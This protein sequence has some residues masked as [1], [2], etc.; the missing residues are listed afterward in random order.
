MVQT[1]K[2]LLE[3]WNSALCGLLMWGAVLLVAIPVRADL[4]EFYTLT[5]LG[6]LGGMSG[7]TISVA[8]GV[9]N[10]GHVV[11]WSYTPAPEASND[12]GNVTQQVFL[13]SNGTMGN[14]LGT[15]GG[16]ENQAYGINNAGQVVGTASRHAFVY[17]NN[18]ITDLVTL[19]ANQALDIND[20]GQV[21]GES[22]TTNA[23]Y[24]FLYSNG[25]MTD[26]GNL[27]GT[28]SQAQGTNDIGQVVGPSGTI[29]DNG[30]Q[31][32]RA[33][34]Y[35]NGSMTDL[36]TLGE[37][38]SIAFDINDAGQAV[39]YADVV[40]ITQPYHAFLYTNGT[41]TD[42]GTLGKTISEARGID[43]TGQVVRW[44]YNDG[45]GAYNAFVYRHGSLSNLN[46]LLD[47]SGKGW[48][49][50]E[51]IAVTDNGQMVGLG[52]NPLG[53]Q[54]A[55]LLTPIPGLLMLL[56][57]RARMVAKGFSF[58][59]WLVCGGG[60]GH[61]D[62]LRRRNGHSVPA[63]HGY[64]QMVSGSGNLSSSELYTKAITQAL[65]ILPRS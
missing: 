12:P 22:F 59:R 15:L 64:P 54:E 51:A 21:A 38:N 44:S 43:S 11:G 31:I 47:G 6:N 56:V 49:L 16:V 52:V 55:F 7:R 4:A 28:Y 48:T 10:A 45:D 37:P 42:V 60:G 23:H 36:G 62:R 53:L 34:L 30:A 41:V 27:G 57:W 19:G 33:F 63:I 20:T 8:Y 29:D 14:L 1:V 65:V 25:T 13:Y 17:S 24:V 5:A 26:L 40:S 46:N 18:T 61:R 58:L 9:N 39:G 32:F 50:E 35:S 3:I 2:R